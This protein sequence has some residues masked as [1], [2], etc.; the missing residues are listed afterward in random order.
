MRMKASV[1]R[2]LRESADRQ[3]DDPSQPLHD[4]DYLED[5]LTMSPRLQLLAQNFA[6][7][8]FMAALLNHFLY[9][10]LAFMIELA[11]EFVRAHTSVEIRDLLDEGSVADDL[12][13]ENSE[14]LK[15]VNAL[16]MAQLPVFPEITH[17]LKTQTATRQL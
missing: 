1:L 5:K 13:K 3:L 9:V 16:L 15:K 11:S 2:T 8:P 4:F 12:A 14:Q 10:H 7:V 17:A 6:G